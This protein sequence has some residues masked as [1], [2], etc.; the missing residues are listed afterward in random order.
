MTDETK[1]ASLA[2]DH[3]QLETSV[4]VTPEK[5]SRSRQRGRPPVT[6]EALQERRASVLKVAGEL[7]VGRASADMTVEQL[8]KAAGISRPTFYR[9]FPEGV[10]QVV[11][12]LIVQANQALVSRIMEVVDADGTIEQRIIA[13]ISAYFQWG[14]DM[15]P[16]TYAIYREGFDEKSPAWRYRQQTIEIIIR[17]MRL[18]SNENGFEHVSDL[19]VETVVSWVESAGANLFRRYPVSAADFDEQ[20]KLT[21]E[22]FLAMIEVVRRPGV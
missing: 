7:L 19:T 1:N 9:W 16:V 22:M 11:D 5:P 12:M 17:L 14:A 18:Q 3:N 10:E 2:I 4:S 13:G 21:T 20:K 8:I 15:G 6:E